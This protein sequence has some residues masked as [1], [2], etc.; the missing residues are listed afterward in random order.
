MVRHEYRQMGRNEG[1]VNGI[2][3]N[4]EDEG[5]INEEEEVKVQN[6]QRK[7]KKKRRGG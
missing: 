5:E 2:Q 7:K 6:R 4:E 3:W 1:I